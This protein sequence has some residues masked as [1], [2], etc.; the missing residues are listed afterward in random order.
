MKHQKILNSAPG[1]A[2][3]A[4]T[5]ALVAAGVLTHVQGA[6][7]TAGTLLVN[8]DATKQTAGAL[9]SIANAGTLGGFFVATGGGATIPKLDLTGGTK[10]IQFDGTSYLQLAT[11]AAGAALVTPPAGIVGV[12]PTVSIEVWALNPEVGSEETMVAWGK[13]GGPDG[14]NLSFNYGSD[15]RWGAVGHWGSPDLGWNSDG[16]SPAANKWH[17]L[18]YTYDGK[19]SRVYADGKL[20]NAE[21]DGA[22]VLNTWDSTSINLATQ[23][24]SDGTTPTGGIRGSLS[25]ARVR[26]HD[27]VLTDAQVAANYTTEKTDFVDPVPAAPIAAERLGKGPVH[28]YSFNDAAIADADGQPIKDS[29]GTANGMVQGEGTSFTGTRLKLSGGPSATAGYGDLPNGLLSSNGKANGGTGEFTFETWFKITGSR[30]WSRVFDFGSSASSDEVPGPGGGGTGLDYLEYSAQIGDDT[31]SRRLELRNE[32]PAGGGGGATSDVGTT[33]FNKDTHVVVTWKES[34]GAVSV[35]ENGKRLGGFTTPA[36]ISDINDVNVWLGRSNWNGDNNL[37]GEFDEVRFYDYVLTPGQ[38]LGDSLAGPDLINNQGVNV[39]ISTDPVDTAVPEGYSATFTVAAKGSSPINFQWSRNGVPIAGA[40]GSSYTIDS[41]TAADNGA[42]FSVV[43]SN[44]VNGKDISAPSKTAKLTLVADPVSMKHRYSFNETSGTVAKDSVGTANGELLGGASLTGGKVK[45]DGN[46]GYVNLPNGIVSSL[47]NNGTI[48][49]WYSYDGGGAWSRV[50]DLGTRV[51]G[52]DGTGNGLDY[53]F[54]TPKTGDGIP[55][56]IANFPDGG[57]TT[58]ISLP[59]YQAV[60][61]EH[62]IAIS[63]SF[64]GNTARMYLDG[65]LVASGPA[66][67]PLSALSADNNNWLGR[68]QFPS[69]PFFAGAINEFRLYSGAMTSAQVAAS[70]TAGPN[71]TAA[72][73]VPTLTVSRDGNNVIVTWPSASTG[74]RLE[75]STTLGASASWTDIGDGTPIT[76]GNFRV[77][78]PVSSAVRFLRARSN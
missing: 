6:I 25:I 19:I 28:R 36:Q 5:L 42:V 7:Q 57:D 71:G 65:V 31:G 78:V 70:F 54:F 24:D 3:P 15:F 47:G 77:V 39:S 75:G 2:L 16:G 30:T 48:E 63:Y 33:T 55:R 1:R 26:I 37:Q 73:P 12:D 59:T 21:Y 44:N 76:G 68:S 56:F 14:T 64:S 35:Y 72:A 60:G 51:D 38:V 61:E 4:F 43:A 45:L 9:K 41:V 11:D 69:D 53:L 18:V 46:D 58:T 52:E 50:F 22:G 40:T 34:T 67:K 10:A 66:S 27:D 49:F 62:A 13:R 29:V 23:L 32:D 8:V 20:A 17:H 74:Y